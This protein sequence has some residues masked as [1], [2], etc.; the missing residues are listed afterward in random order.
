MEEKEFNYINV[1]PFIDV[2]LVL[3]TIVL[4]TSTFVAAGLIPIELPK[5]TQKH[6][7][8]MKTRIVEIDRNGII[9]YQGV[10]V[11]LDRL[12]RNVQMMERETPFLIRADANLAL[13]DFVEVLDLLKSMNFTKISLQTEER[14][15]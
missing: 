7:S 10:P 13:Q 2:M 5:V 14:T 4:M 8:A 15:R 3:L 11:D 12:R 1:V 6:E 9:Y